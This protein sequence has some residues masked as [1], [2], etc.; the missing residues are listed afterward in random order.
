MVAKP[1]VGKSTIAYELAVKIAQ[2][3]PFLGRITKK[4][5]VLILALEEHRREVKQRLFSLGAAPLSNI[6]VHIG[7]LADSADMVNELKIYIV[8]HGITLVIFD[9]LN[10]FW[11]V[12]DENDAVGVTRAITPILSLARDSNAAVL[13]VHHARKSEGDYGDEIR[14]SGALFSL[15]DVA[16]VIKRHEVETQRKLTAISRYPE[17]PADL[18]IERREHGHEALGSSVEAGRSAKMARLQAELTDTPESVETLAERAA[19]SKGAA[20]PLLDSLVAQNRATRMGA[21]KRSDP[22]RYS[23]FVPVSS[24]RDGCHNETKGSTTV[25]DPELFSSDG[26]VSLGGTTLR[27]E[28]KER[29]TKEEE[30]VSFRGDGG[31]TKHNGTEENQ[32]CE[33][34]VFRVD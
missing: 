24:L 16:V 32:N 8:E 1:K 25:N 17:T 28:T 23:H 31:H 6:H 20:Y 15:L 11:R 21:G 34:E 33:E 2:G 13:L 4:G 26:F 19:I 27:R 29:Q 12:K 5:P 9:T 18:I 10:S 3:Q 30:L 22:Y 7:P 14:G